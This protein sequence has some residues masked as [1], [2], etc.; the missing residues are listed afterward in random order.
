MSIFSGGSLHRKRPY[1]TD[2]SVNL[3]QELIDAYIAIGPVGNKFIA[4]VRKASRPLVFVDYEGITI[5]AQGN[6]VHARK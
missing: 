4:L 2:P 3:R 5:A 6:S 1:W